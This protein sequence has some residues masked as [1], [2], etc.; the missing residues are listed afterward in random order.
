[1]KNILS[2]LL[3]S[4]ILFGCSENRVLLDELTNKRTEKS[5]LMYYEGVLFNGIG[6]DIYE[7]GQLELEWNYKDGKMDGLQK[8]WYKNGH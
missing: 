5:E 4:V 2:I 3:V 1:M 6:F 8:E 7:N